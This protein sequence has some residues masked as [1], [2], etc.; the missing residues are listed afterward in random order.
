LFRFL[1][2][3][4]VLIGTAHAETGHPYAPKPWGEKKTFARYKIS[5]NW[6]ANGWLYVNSR[7]FIDHVKTV[8]V[9]YQCESCYPGATL[10]K[11]GFPQPCTGI[12]D[13][14]GAYDGVLY[15][16]EAVNPNGVF[17]SPFLP[18][19][20][21]RPVQGEQLTGCSYLL[22]PC[23]FTNKNLNTFDCWTYRTL[24]HFDTWG[25][26]ADVWVTSL[27]ENVS[28]FGNSKYN[29]AWARGIGLVHFWFLLPDGQGWE[30]YVVDY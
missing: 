19:L 23:G 14:W 9:P 7:I 10:W 5:A 22:G 17:I 21:Y 6:S 25:S 18:K 13:A 20:T 29:Y 27:D 8:I 11:Q 12:V 30:Y 2:I 3:F 28:N 16:G 15:L 1:I 24:Q 26:F 4:F